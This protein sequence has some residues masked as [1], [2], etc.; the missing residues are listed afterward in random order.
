[1]KLKTCRILGL[2]V[3]GAIL[4]LAA[5][6]ASLDST[7]LAGIGFALAIAD[8]AFFILFHRCPHCGH[9]LRAGGDYCPYCG[10]KVND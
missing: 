3:A 1:M 7:V 10:E 6:A 2:S 4:I 8:G 5:M 9:S